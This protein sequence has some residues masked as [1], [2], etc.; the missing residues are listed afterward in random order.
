MILKLSFQLS[1]FIFPNIGPIFQNLQK[2]SEITGP[3]IEFYT[4]NG[5]E[6][7]ISM[8]KL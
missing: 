6:K 4:Y 8:Q 7:G 3:K 2:S 1:V 5:M